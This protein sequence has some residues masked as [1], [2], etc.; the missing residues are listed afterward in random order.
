MSGTI[1]CLCA[2]MIVCGLK[3]HPLPYRSPS[4]FVK[5]P[6]S[7]WMSYEDILADGDTYFDDLKC[8]CLILS[9]Q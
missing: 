4:Y 1:G 8:L 7:S 5:T 2:A 3:L 6:I 9:L